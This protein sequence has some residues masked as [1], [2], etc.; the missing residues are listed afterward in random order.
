MVYFLA[1]QRKPFTDGELI[2]SCLIAIATEMCLEK[3]NLF[4]TF[5][6]NSCSELRTVGATPVVN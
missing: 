6:E 1:K 5:G 4:K 3:I 2:K